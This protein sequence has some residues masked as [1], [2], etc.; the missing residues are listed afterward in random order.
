MRIAH[1]DI[2]VFI[3]QVP[4]MGHS[5]IEISPVN[6]IISPQTGQANFR[7]TLK[8]LSLD[9]DNRDMKLR[10]VARS[11]RFA[12]VCVCVLLL[13]LLLLLLFFVS[14]SCDRLCVPRRRLILIPSGLFLL[15]CYKSHMYTNIQPQYSS[16]RC[17]PFTRYEGCGQTLAYHTI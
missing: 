4:N 1:D 2:R 13:L 3:S 5:M 14:T 15:G 17:R 9:H 16:H 10:V 8:Q 6:P 7:V 11:S 12:R